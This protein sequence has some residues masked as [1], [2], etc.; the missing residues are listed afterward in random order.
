MVIFDDRDFPFTDPR[1]APDFGPMADL[2]A[3][4]ELRTGAL[5]TAERLAREW[6]A[7]VGALRVPEPL[8]AIVRERSK[9]LVNAL[10]D[11][12]D[13]F[14]CVNGRWTFPS[15]RFELGPGQAILEEP[16]GAV[17]AAELSRA[18]AESFLTTK[19]LPEHIERLTHDGQ[20]L[21][22]RPWDVLGLLPRALLTDLLAMSMVREA[23]QAPREEQN[24]P[25]GVTII[26]D[27]AVAIDSRARVYPSVVLDVEEGPIAIEAGAVVRP[28]AIVRGPAYIGKQST[29]LEHALVKP[30]TVVGPVCKIAGEVGATIFQGFSNKAH[31]GHLGDS[32]V[33]EWVNFGAGT[34]NSN[35]LNTYGEILVK[36]RPTARR[37]RTGL[38]Y[39]GAIVGDHVK[40]AINTRL[41]TGSV[42]GTGSMIAT[43]APPPATVDAFMWM[44]DKGAHAYQWSKF[45]DVAHA[46]MKRRDVELSDA[47]FDRLKTLHTKATEA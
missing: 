41:M 18:D 44:T 19:A 21:S 46:V 4:F 42:I 11:G 28:G 14:F 31:D 12:E 45:I 38:M 32:Y 25:L 26:G 20:L 1:A 30:N 24:V 34:T 6:P 43:T 9:V 37:E 17:V 15:S 33:G 2:R 47:I 22:R 16:G 36:L 8:E 40:F 7:G 5:T 3:F 29:V 27:E 39:F 23:G 13:S 10:P 35:L